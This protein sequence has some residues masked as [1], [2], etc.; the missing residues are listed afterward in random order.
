MPIGNSFEKIRVVGVL[1]RGEDFD[2]NIFFKQGNAYD[3][4]RHI[5]GNLNL[6]EMAEATK[7]ENKKECQSAIIE[8]IDT[9]AVE[10]FQKQQSYNI[11]LSG[12][13]QPPFPRTLAGF[14]F[15]QGNNIEYWTKLALLGFTGSVFLTL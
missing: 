9:S 14:I 15:T 3:E 5:T 13:I 11:D 12:T 8:K 1:S 7:F 2:K 10:E 4:Q 6:I